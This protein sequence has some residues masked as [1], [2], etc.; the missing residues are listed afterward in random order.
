MSEHG[1]IASSAGPSASHSC[2]SEAPIAQLRRGQA[3]TVELNESAGAACSATPSVSTGRSDTH[4]RR[5]VLQPTSDVDLSRLDAKRHQLN[6]VNSSPARR[7]SLALSQCV[8][9]RLRQSLA[10]R[11]RRTQ[12]RL[13]QL[14]RQNGRMHA[15]PATTTTMTTTTTPTRMTAQPSSRADKV[16]RVRRRSQEFTLSISF[17]SSSCSLARASSQKSPIHS[18]APS[19]L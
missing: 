6:D 15:K 4:Q 2:V 14:R 18:P 12:L 9:T 13:E 17:T 19:G 16:G 7:A 3:F 8:P 5:R 1:A 11:E 10:E